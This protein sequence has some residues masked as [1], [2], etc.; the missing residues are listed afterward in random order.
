MKL[1]LALFFFSIFTVLSY[2]IWRKHVFKILSGWSGEAESR[3]GRH[4][5]LSTVSLSS[6]T[7]S[8]ALSTRSFS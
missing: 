8:G 7:V 3:I 5:L 4:L 6:Y 2:L 1:A